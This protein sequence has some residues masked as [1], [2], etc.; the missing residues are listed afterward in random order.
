MPNELRRQISDPKVLRALADPIRY[1]I[2][3]HLM[4]VGPRTASQCAAVVGATASNCS[5]HLRELERFGLVERAPATETTDGRERPWL[6]AVT[7]L[8]QEV[9]ADAA[10]PVATLA[11]RELLHIG[12]ED[13]AA[14]AHAAIDR[15]D[16][17][18]PDW[19]AAETL[20]TYGLK[21]TSDELAE[22]TAQVD[23]LLRP[24]IG[25]TRG[26]TPKDARNVHV[27]FRAFRRRDDQ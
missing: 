17:L 5:Y 26:G 20:A 14:L 10:D 11:Q 1:R 21:L 9:P 15:H 7:G 2:L 23:A 6:P 27:A 19:Q 16:E 8:S 13:D 25:L 22:L 24:F 18:S 12:I 3:T 4:A